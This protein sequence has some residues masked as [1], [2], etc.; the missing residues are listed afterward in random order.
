MSVQNKT[1]IGNRLF[2][3]KKENS[4]IRKF[5]PINSVVESTA[6]K[7]NGKTSSLIDSLSSINPSLLFM[8]PIEELKK[9]IDYSMKIVKIK[10]YPTNNSELSFNC[11]RL[12]NKFEFKIVNYKLNEDQSCYYLKLK[13]KQ[14][15]VSSKELIS[16]F[17]IALNSI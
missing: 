4:H 10:Y 9:K 17:V 6:N 12:G 3:Q 2:K 1:S 16:N 14:S 11:E 15:N 5:S 8:L 13:M 7:N